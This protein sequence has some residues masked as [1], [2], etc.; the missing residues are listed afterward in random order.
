MHCRKLIYEYQ[1]FDLQKDG[2]DN[3]VQ[4]I[5]RLRR[6]DLPELRAIFPRLRRTRAWAR[7]T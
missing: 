1:Y 4:Q 5:D 3:C 2:G 7:R 6:L